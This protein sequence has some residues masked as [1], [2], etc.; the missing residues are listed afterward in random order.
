[1]GV[2][3]LTPNLDTIL[4]KSAQAT[5]DFIKEKTL[6]QLENAIAKSLS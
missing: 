4:A 3:K 2:P 1:V 5:V 6:A